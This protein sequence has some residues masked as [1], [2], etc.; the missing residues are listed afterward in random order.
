MVRWFEPDEDWFWGY[1]AEDVHRW[2]RTLRRPHHHPLDQPDPG[3]GWSRPAGLGA[4][5][6]LIDQHVDPD[7]EASMGSIISSPGAS[8]G[9][10]TSSSSAGGSPGRAMRSSW[11]RPGCRRRGRAWRAARRADDGP[12][13]RLLPG[14]VGRTRLRRARAPEHRVLRRVRG[15]GRAAR[16]GHRPPPGRLAV[17]HRRRVRAGGGATAFVAGHRRLGVDDSE[18]LA[19][20]EARRRFVWL[21]P[22]VTAASYRADDGWVSP[23]EVTY[24]FAGERRDLPPAH[25]RDP[26]GHGG[27]RGRRR[28][29]DRGDDRHAPVVLAAGPFSRGLAA[30]AGVACRWRPPPPPAMSRPGPRSPPMAR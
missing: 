20:D 8:R 15:A 28:R 22:D 13:G 17:H 27:R 12:V 24:G 26:P 6:E 10:P 25:D 11:A 21:G 19:G 3:A 16:L 1:G 7:R 29:D 23:Y 5:L 14:P 30:T 9:P 2:T 18:A 4:P